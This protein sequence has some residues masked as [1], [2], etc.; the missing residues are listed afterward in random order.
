MGSKMEFEDLNL[1]EPQKFF[2]ELVKKA[3]EG[4]QSDFEFIRSYEMLKVARLYKK[5]TKKVHKLFNS[6]VKS[7]LDAY[8][9]SILT[10]EQKI[11]A[12]LSVKQFEACAK[13]YE[14]ECAIAK[15]MLSEYRT[16]VLSGH[17]MEQFFFC[18]VRPDNECVDYRKLPWKLF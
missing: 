6:L 13:Y 18:G 9:K 1:T 5:G 17:I 14:N 11:E 4:K 16:Y 2:A 8:A 10:D 15:D 7:I 12:L 3:L